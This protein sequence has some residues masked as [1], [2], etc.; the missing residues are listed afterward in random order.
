MLLLPKYPTIWELAANLCPSERVC[1][2][3]IGLVKSQF[4]ALGEYP[5]SEIACYLVNSS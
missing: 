3:L 4:R 2:E 1:D 5:E